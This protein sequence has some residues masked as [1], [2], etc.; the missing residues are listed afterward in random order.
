MGRERIVVRSRTDNFRSVLGYL[1]LMGEDRVRVDISQ[2][3]VVPVELV[4]LDGKKEL[5]EPVAG[6]AVVYRQSVK[7]KGGRP[8]ITYKE[9]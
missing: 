5:L 3:K 1:Q 4:G 7:F 6:T 9:R 8:Y 2:R